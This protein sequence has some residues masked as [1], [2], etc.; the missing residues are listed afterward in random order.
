MSH[1]SRLSMSLFSLQFYNEN[2]Y[3]VI[4][5]CSELPSAFCFDSVFLNEHLIFRNH[6]SK[7]ITINIKN[8]IIIISHIVRLYVDLRVLYVWEISQLIL[9]APKLLAFQGTQCISDEVTMSLWG[10][11]KAY[12]VCIAVCILRLNSTFKIN[13]SFTAFLSSQPSS[14]NND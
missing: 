14:N 2:S 6:V 10:A 1:F 12:F 5:F 13:I 4:M 3:K 11:W 8:Y 7:A 9:S